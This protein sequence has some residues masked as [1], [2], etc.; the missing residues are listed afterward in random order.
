VCVYIYIYIYIYIYKKEKCTQETGFSE[1]KK[2]MAQGQ[3]IEKNLLFIIFP[4]GEL[5]LKN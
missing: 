3:G 4:F 1:E 5:K 2:L